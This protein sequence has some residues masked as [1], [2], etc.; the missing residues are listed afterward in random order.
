MMNY[1]WAGMIII[2]VGFSALNGRLLELNNV[3]F[4]SCEDAV[5]FVIGL[6]GIMA[7]WSGIMNIAKGS[8][9][10]KKIERGAR[11]II[12][13]LFPEEKNEETITYIIMNMVANLFGVGNSATVFGLKA[14]QG[15]N[16]S[17]KKSQYANN[18]MC[19]FLA[20]NMAS[21]QLIPITIIKIRSEAG[22]MNPVEIIMPTII[23][24]TIHT[25]SAILMCKYY[26]RK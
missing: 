1:I 2:G 22:S 24:T 8:G 19:M 23:V 16:L 25:V 14:M 9:L 4:K 20:I 7:V 21:I 13:F 5:Y 3:L 11:P 26:E 17:N 10:M 18:A 15:M 6:S 12:H